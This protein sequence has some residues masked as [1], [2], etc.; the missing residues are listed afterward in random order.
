MTYKHFSPKTDPKIDW[1]RVDHGALERLDYA[2]DLV[3]FPL[4][5]T[6]NF[7]PG[8]DQLSHGET[9]CTAFDLRIPDVEETAQWIRDKHFSSAAPLFQKGKGKNTYE[10][11]L[12]QPVFI[13]A[14]K[15]IR[16]IKALQLA[17]FRR[18]GVNINPGSAHIHVDDSLTQLAITGRVIFME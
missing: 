9:P 5:V 10:W 13:N 3:G 16:I 6:S 1:A 15:G 17:G 14:P 4:I 18:I 11:M 12:F 2:R 8:K 7:R